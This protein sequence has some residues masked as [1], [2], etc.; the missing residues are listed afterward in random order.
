MLKLI[1]GLRTNGN[2]YT[3][4]GAT[5]EDIGIKDSEGQP[6]LVPVTMEYGEVN[7]PADA[8]RFSR[9]KELEQKLVNEER[10]NIK[11]ELK[12]KH[13]GAIIELS[14]INISSL[15]RKALSELSKHLTLKQSAK[16][17]QAS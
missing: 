11:K 16:T 13:P 14:S 1:Y 7:V 10:R 9:W 8:E 4:T 15:R 17:E 12:K 6:I 2:T 3:W 5:H